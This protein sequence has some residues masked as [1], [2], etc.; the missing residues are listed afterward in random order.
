MADRWQIEKTLASEGIATACNTRVIT[1]NESNKLKYFPLIWS[2]LWRKPLDALLTWLTVTV[3]FALFG[4]MLGV[5]ATV[6]ATL[7]AASPTTIY[8]NPRFPSVRLQIGM[9]DQIARIDGVSA[10]AVFFQLW[11]R[12]GD[13]PTAVQVM[14]FDEGAREAVPYWG[15]KPEQW[16][17][18]FATRDG[19]YISR[20]TATKF[21]LKVG[22]TFVVTTEPGRRA[23]GGRAWS[24]QV[25]NILPDVPTSGG[26]MI[27]NYHYLDDS[28]PAANRGQDVQF[29]VKIADP[30]RAVEISRQIDRMFTNSGTSTTSTSMRLTLESLLNS[31]GHQ[32]LAITIVGA[33]GL[34]MILVLI[35]NAIAQS[36][37]QRIPEFA[38]LRTVGFRNVHIMGLVFAEATIPCLAGALIGTLL[39]TQLVHWPAKFLPAEFSGLP[40]PTL[41]I[42]VM[43]RALA[44][45]L[46]IA[47]ASAAAPLA[48]VSRMSVV[49]QLARTAR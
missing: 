33:A 11:G 23:D 41:S 22:D 19:L 42:E 20:K 28:R 2:A 39:A 5:N 38:V 48:R 31:S 6:R 47:C 25:L 18:L 30:A 34:F 29:T 37:R 45:A 35:A 14:S 3:A 40:T 26:F 49:S 1:G 9:R 43:L 44:A 16:D 10:V 46:V 8:V 13:L 4:L 27:G 24:F 7:E 17:R 12:R 15:L 21:N 32:T 36:V